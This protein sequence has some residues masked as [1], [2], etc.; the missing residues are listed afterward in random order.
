MAHWEGLVDA[1]ALFGFLGWGLPLKLE[2]P[3][4]HKRSFWQGWERQSLRDAQQAATP[5]RQRFLEAE[6]LPGP[7]LWKVGPNQ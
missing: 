1:P 2:H 6:V 3:P 5:L 4:P 7:P